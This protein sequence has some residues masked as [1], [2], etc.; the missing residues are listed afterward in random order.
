LIT[1]LPHSI[2][3]QIM[4]NKNQF[5]LLSKEVLSQEIDDET[6]L[7]DMKS[8]NYFGLNYVGKRV[9]DIITTGANID[10]IVQ[11]LLEEF[12]VEENQL[13]KDIN[14]LIQQLLDT[15]L[16]EPIT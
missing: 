2:V 15:G 7:L 12:D 5:F 6:V 13:E 1:A 8:E 14:E 11:T 3:I 4:I 16:I 10:T 9:L